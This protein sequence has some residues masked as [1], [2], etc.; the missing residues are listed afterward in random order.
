MQFTDALT[1]L[2]RTLLSAERIEY[3]STSGRAKDID[4][5]HGK[6]GR[7]GKSYTDPLNEIT[8]L[9]GVRIVCYDTATVHKIGEVIAKNFSVDGLNSVDK[10]KQLDPDQFGYLSVHYVVSLDARRKELPE[11]QQFLN[12]KA[13]VQ[14]RTTLQHAWAVLDHSLRYKSSFDVPRELR[15]QLYRI[16]ALLELVDD[17]FLRLKE[18]SEELRLSYAKDVKAGRLD[19][20]VNA[21]S[22]DAFV[23]RNTVTLQSLS[24]V[25]E[26]VGFAIAPPPPNQKTPWTNL[27]RTLEAAHVGT[28][29]KFDE[30]LRRF[31][32]LAESSLNSLARRWSTETAS[33]RLVLD[34]STLLRIAVVLSLSKARALETISSVPFGPSLQS[35]ITHELE[36][37]P[38]VSVPSEAAAATEA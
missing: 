32:P 22:V 4:S 20:E 8:D 23:K 25:A 7:E 1:S 37:L 11:Y 3:L 13:E 12:M 30:A 36:S 27:V 21:D 2:L 6:V 5:F 15:R 14:V 19:A 34:P 9:C 33:P 31:L 26:D 24:R 38:T 16:S 28:L 17:E 35:V 29:Q 18:A 10:S